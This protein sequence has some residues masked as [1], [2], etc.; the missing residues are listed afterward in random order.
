MVTVQN[1]MVAAAAFA[2]L[3][4]S[5]GHVAELIMAEN[6]SATTP[7]RDGQAH[8]DAQAMGAVLDHQH[9]S[10]GLSVEQ[11]SIRTLAIQT[12]TGGRSAR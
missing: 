1:A 9:V 6:S 3:E 12:T 8:G 10:D 5:T 2:A 11:T 7:S 4:A